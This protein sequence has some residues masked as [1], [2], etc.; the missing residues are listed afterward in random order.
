MA[1]NYFQTTIQPDVPTKIWEEIKNDPMFSKYFDIDRDEPL[2]LVEDNMGKYTYL[3]SMY[4]FDGLA[5]TRLLQEVLRR[6]PEI[7]CFEIEGAS[8][9]SKMRPGEF[10]GHC[11]FV[12]RGFSR[13]GGTGSLLTKYRGEYKRTLVARGS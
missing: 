5:V 11:G 6:C 8:T 12:G 1:D 7:E 2:G 3:Y 10:G 9:C 13:W 4:G